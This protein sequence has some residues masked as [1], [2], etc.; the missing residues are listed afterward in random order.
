MPIPKLSSV[1]GIF[2][3][4]LG[5]LDSNTFVRNVSQNMLTQELQLASVFKLAANRIFFNGAYPGPLGGPTGEIGQFADTNFVYA[6]AGNSFF[7]AGLDNRAGYDQTA[8]IVQ[9]I[10]FTDRY[11]ADPVADVLFNAFAVPA[12]SRVGIV[13]ANDVT[14]SFS[15]NDHD[16]G[17]AAKRVYPIGNTLVFGQTLLNV[18]EV[19]DL[20]Q[21]FGF[22]QTLDTVGTDFG[23]DTSQAFIKQHVSFRVQG[24]RCPEKEYTPFIGESGDTSYPEVSVSAP[25][26][27]S[28]T[29]TLTYPRVGPTT[30]LVLKNPEFGNS[31]TIR[32]TKIDRVTRGGDRKFFSDSNWS[33]TQSFRL[34][35]SN[36]CDTTATIDQ[37]INFL[38]DSLGKEI[39]LLDWEGRQWKG[40]VVVPETEVIPQVGGHRVVIVFE[41][42]LA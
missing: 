31:D 39:G 30:T 20:F 3:I 13:F 26:L 10:G 25:T 40:I 29:L 8:D 21:G 32:F 4:T 6:D 22:T 23:G 9:Y 33:E 42:E 36:I 19:D 18:P 2:P 35:I 5:E 28:D 38:N 11:F 12:T 17:E 16:L 24:Q 7:D 14:L 34:T 41:G 37:I 27:G 15:W 1:D